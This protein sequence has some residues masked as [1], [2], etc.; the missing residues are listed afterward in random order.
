MANKVNFGLKS[1]HYATI[2]YTSGVPSWGTPVSVPGAVSLSLSK[3][4]SDTDF[5]AD[6][7]KYFHLAGNSGYEGTLEMALIP[8]K[9]REDL[10]GNTTTTTGKLLV[11]D[12]DAQPTEFALMF[13]IDGDASPTRYCMFR[14]VAGRPDIAGDTKAESTEVKTQTC[15]I[16]VM[17]VLDPMASSPINGK[18]YYKTTANTPSGTFTSFFSS[19]DTTLA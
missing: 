11:E 16:T 19:V 18:T 3:S 14:C 2:T 4:G 12:V 9:M 1:V 17:P 13:E 7:V 6:D 8:D 10:W 15:D 5:Y